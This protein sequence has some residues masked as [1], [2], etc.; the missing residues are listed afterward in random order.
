MKVMAIVQARM[1][2]TRLPGKV[3]EPINGIPLIEYLLKRVSKSKKID[4]I[5]VATSDAREDDVLEKYLVGIGYQCHRGSEANVLERY[6][7]ALEV[8][9]PDVIVRIT[10]D[11]PLIDPILIDKIIDTF[12]EKNV[13]YVSNI[14]PP[15]F[16]D[17]QDIE[18]FSAEVLKSL[19]NKSLTGHDCEH[20]TPYIRN[21]GEYTTFNFS[22]EID[23]SKKRWT[24]DE[25]SDLKVI[26]NV[27][28]QFK[29]HLDFSWIDV[30]NLQDENP[31]LFIENQLLE[32][33]EGS[34]M[35][36]GQKLWRRAK[37]IIPGG[38]MLLSKRPE[39][40]LPE[41]W[42]TYFNKAKGCL[43]WDL[44][45]N[46]FKD[47]SIMGVGTNI[48]GYGHE[49]V[50]ESVKK[51]IELGNMSTLN[52]PE[53][54]Y[55]AETLLKI[56]PWAQMVRF[57]RTGGEA[58]ALAIRIARAYSKSDKVAICGY[59]G[60]H[61]WYLAANLGATE[62]LDGHLLPGLEPNGVPR[63]LKNTVYPFS[64][65]NLEHLEEL[66]KEKNIGIIKMEV[67][68]NEEP[69]N[70]FLIKVREL[71]TKNNIILIFDE[72]TSGFRETFGGLHLKYGVEPDISI[73]GKALGNGYAITAVV[74][75]SKVMDAAQSS[76]ISSTFWT[77]RIGP[78]AALKT[79]EVMKREKSWEIISA[80]GHEI[81]KRWNDMAAKYQIDIKVNGLS[82]LAS[83]SFNSPKNLEYKTLI[84]QEMLNAGFLAS[85]VIYVS[86]AHEQA[87][88]DEYF[89]Y[90]ENIFS[91]I[92]KCENGLDVHSLLKYPVCQSGF[93]R[94]N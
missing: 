66:V 16:P 27:C 2:S 88:V 57:A 44:D 77:E 71:A 84:S 65:N 90:L 70:N 72:C 61:D 41:G 42:P 19:V 50:D 6:L 58:N 69:Q 29:A 37:N 68:R 43:V 54:V 36:S 81:K 1:K 17:G 52:C 83:F 49:E 30:V 73:F 78:A 31:K 89:Y 53:E 28:D 33:N 51:V 18:V 34:R 26:R 32:R 79:L 85:N 4:S 48:L 24:V 74:G 91:L 12:F 62:N 63:S 55:L 3:M 82:A 75:R 56:N 39:M 47:M 45:G 92:C 60:W 11:C 7:G 93:K 23:H 80:K 87:V 15:T 46:V 5:I 8:Y 67:Y 25:F 59:H 40:F 94:L 20:V 76:F 22:S 86:L 35:N 9:A 64:Y 10:G 14:S 13:D 21:S 38:G